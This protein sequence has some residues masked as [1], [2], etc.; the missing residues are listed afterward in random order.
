[1]G[2]NVGHRKRLD[3]KV[4]EYGLESLE[5]HEQL[6]FILFTAVPRGD[7]NRIAHRLLEHFGS[8]AGVLN[9]DV[10]QL[11]RF[12]GVGHRTAMFLVSLPQM[13]GVYE[14]SIKNGADAPSF[15]STEEIED[16]VKTYFFNKLI[17][18][19]YMFSLNSTY[20]LMHVTKISDGVEAE[21]VIYPRNV[22]RNA[23]YDRASAI[24]IAHNHPCG[25]VN[26]SMNDVRVSREISKALNT[27]GIELHDSVI[28]AQGKFY[29]LRDNGYLDELCG[30][31]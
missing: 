5:M 17:E 14:R 28:V 10:R 1:M 25:S 2:E 16:Q 22:A 20:K 27:L 18:C 29:S 9:A 30:H 21:N 7:T 24:V 26:P 3:K 15:K 12:E 13:L 4:C 6:E 8:I 31:Y 19:S 23:L 11:E